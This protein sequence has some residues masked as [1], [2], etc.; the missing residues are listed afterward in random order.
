MSKY[1]G[2]CDFGDTWMIHGE[3]YILNSNVYIGENI[4]PL[5]I[6]SYKDALP[7]FP[8]LVSLAAFNNVEGKGEIRLSTE[9]FI[10]REERE[11]LGW[12]LRDAKKYFKKCKRI[13]KEF[14]ADEATKALS[15]FEYEKNIY[16]PIAEEVK[17]DGIKAKIPDRVHLPMHEYYRKELYD[18][19]I[20]AGYDSTKAAKWAYGW[21]RVFINDLPD[22]I[23]KG[24]NHECD[25][26]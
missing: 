15:S 20:K 8:Y 26:K 3:G 25:D 17:K 5:R 14:D 9:S 21:H 13:K 12:I 10:D 23:K 11:H 18:D 16:M 22:S 2:K 19:M 4:V 6:D 24:D 1:S 7:Y